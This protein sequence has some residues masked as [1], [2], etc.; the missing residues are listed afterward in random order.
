MIGTLICQVGLAAVLV[1]PATLRAQERDLQGARPIKV[2]V[3]ITTASIA[4]DTATLGYVVENLRSGDEDLT[5]FLV[6]VPAPVIDMPAPRLGRWL[7]DPRYGDDP[8]AQWALFRSELLHPGESTSELVLVAR[9]V[10]GLVRYWATPNLMAHP[11]DIDD[12]PNRDDVFVFSDTGTT[13]GIVPVP[14]GATPASLTRRLV[15]LLG[16]SC[17]SLRWIDQPGVCH[18]IEVKLRHAQDALATGKVES[19]RGELRAL[20]G[21]LEAQHGTEPGKHVSGQAYALLHPNVIFLL[22]RL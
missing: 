13:V 8:I 11:V 22:G 10:P 19:A 18:G 4:G 17:G 2:R 15:S 9:G 7:T 5:G 14:K 20:A 21:E 3:H 16:R 1:L 6:G 12:D